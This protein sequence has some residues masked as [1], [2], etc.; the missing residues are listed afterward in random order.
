MPVVPTESSPVMARLAYRAVKPLFGTPVYTMMLRTDAEVRLAG[1]PP[2]LWP[3]DP[4]EG[5]KLFRDS[6]SFVAEQGQLGDVT[7]HVDGA[8]ESRLAALHGFS[9]LRHLR[10]LGGEDARDKARRR[11]LAW[12]DLYPAWNPVAWRSDI[13]ANRLVAWL[14]H[15]PAFFVGDDKLAGRLMSSMMLQLRH[16]RRV[17]PHELNGAPRL[18][19][20]KGLVI[21]SACIEVEQRR[22]PQALEMLGREI[23]RQVLP[24]GGHACRC[25]TDHLEVLRDLIEVQATLDAL[26]MPVP[27]VVRT[28]IDRMAPM[29]R[30]FRHGDGGFALMN[31]S[32]EG[33]PSE[34]DQILARTGVRDRPPDSAPD[35][36]FDRI[37]A[38]RMVVICDTGA[39][40]PAG[41][42]QH[43]HAGTLSV[44][45]SVGDDRLIVNCGAGPNVSRDWQ[46]AQRATAAHST[47]MV[48]ETNSSALL[49]TGGLG[50][51]RANASAVRNESDGQVWLEAQHDGY[52]SPLS[53]VHR[54][55]IYMAPT[56]DDMR[57]EDMLEGKGGCG[58]TL[59]LHLHPR[60]QASV[61]HDRAGALLRLPDGEGW[62]LRASGATIDLEDSV[63]LGTPGQMRR[64]QQIVMSGT[65]TAGQTVVKWALQRD[66]SAG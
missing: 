64:A 35:S 20:L 44:E 49:Q 18:R 13:V 52:K 16:L 30:F 15:F 4:R 27:Q 5:E 40:P 46:L 9:W 7:D 3:G 25:P 24:D 47:V 63:Y 21:G 12:A 43:A 14:T 55:R 57:A 38:G 11:A 58:F 2:D 39:P 62:R 26:H 10:A 65:T 23:R 32:D 19:A 22:L 42:D 6:L 1:A 61:Q 45:I 48:E 56:G 34:I 28:T 50:D 53:L 36:G 41:L 54:R 51:R 60:V 17:A 8:G 37:V 59:R 33:D 29:V 31:G 66:T